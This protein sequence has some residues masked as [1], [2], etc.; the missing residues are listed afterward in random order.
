MA[1]LRKRGA[2]AGLTCV[3]VAAGLSLLWRPAHSMPDAV[4][5]PILKEHPK[6]A[7]EA[8]AVFYHSDHQSYGC[9]SCH[10][11]LFPE[12]PQG[13]THAEMREE[14]FCAVCHDGRAAFDV[15]KADCTICHV[16]E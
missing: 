4:R 16:P 6:G 15:D 14:R 12:W 9:A 7:P 3:L 8:A 2:L 13:F 5:I 10:P 11:A 1:N